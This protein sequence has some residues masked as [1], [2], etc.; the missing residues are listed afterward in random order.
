MRTSG[1]ER[2]WA[3]TLDELRAFGADVAEGITRC[4]NNEDFYLQMVESIKDEE[5]FD[6]LE[7]AVAARDLD[8]AFDIAH[9]LKG[10][11]TNLAL[12]PLYAAHHVVG[13][14]GVGKEQVIHPAI[15]E[16]LPI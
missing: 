9:S 13:A 10:I 5:A 12:T 3:V 1:Q 14:V 11:L 16:V 15:E 6:S 7:H 8:A 4:L 2:E